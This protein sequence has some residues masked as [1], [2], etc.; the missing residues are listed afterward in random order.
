MVFPS[1]YSLETPDIISLPVLRSSRA[2]APITVVGIGS[3]WGNHPF[4]PGAREQ[5]HR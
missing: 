1:V 2:P 3:R 4:F 5:V